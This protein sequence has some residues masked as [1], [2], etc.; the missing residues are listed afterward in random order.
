MG[1]MGDV[2]RA[3]LEPLVKL[4]DGVGLEIGPLAEPIVLLQDHDVRYVDVFDQE[5]LRKHY[6]DDGSVECDDIPVMDFT[7][8]TD[9]G[10]LTLAEAVRRDAPY[11]Y[12]VACHVIEHVPGSDRLAR[13]RC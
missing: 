10:V 5:W 3:R 9:A 4:P 11:A 12:V 6:R 7:L 1:L 13:G 8:S 2:R